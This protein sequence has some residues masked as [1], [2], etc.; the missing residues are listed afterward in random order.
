MTRIQVEELWSQSDEWSLDLFVGAAAQDDLAR[1]LLALEGADGGTR[2]RIE[3]LLDAWAARLPTPRVDTASGQADLLTTLLVD[4]LGLRGDQVDY[5]HPV[6]SQIS[7]VL[8]R[9]RG[10]PILL[11]VVWMEVGRRAGMPVEGIGLPGHFIVRVGGEG[12][13]Y[14][15]PFE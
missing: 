2:Q 14:A 15:D 5:T 3:A 10:L 12:G 6:N 8:E 4:E 9:R 7:K 1:A 13:E 11:S